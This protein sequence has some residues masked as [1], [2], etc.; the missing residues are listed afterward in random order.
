MHITKWAL[1]KLK[2]IEELERLSADVFCLQE[3]TERSLH[4]TF[5]PSFKKLGLECA[6]FGVAKDE[7]F[8]KSAP[9]SSDTMMSRKLLDPRT[10]G[11]AVFCDSNVV[12]VLSSKRVFLRDFA[13]LGSSR[14]EEFCADVHGKTNIMVML[15]LEIIGTGKKVVLANTHLFWD[16]KREDIKTIQG[17]AVAGALSKFCEVNGF[18]T[19]DPPPIILCGDFNGMPYR[20]GN[21]K[22]NP[23]TD[24]NPA[25]DSVVADTAVPDSALFEL[26]TS[27][28]LPIDHPQHPDRWYTRVIPPLM[29]PRIGPLSTPWRLRNTFML[30]PF[31]PFAPAFTTKTNDFAGWIDHIWVDD[32]QV[33]VT[34]TLVPPV[35]S[36]DPCASKLSQDFPPMPNS[37]TF[38]TPILLAILTHIFTLFGFFTEICIGPHPARHYCNY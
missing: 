30:T 27:G 4:K 8:S 19:S 12:K 24:A 31:V 29:C 38:A 18:S 26:L 23:S 14:S 6:G 3:I 34:H 20:P 16:P 5:V 21:S 35:C 7:K 13:P 9:S 15:L 22:N 10:L 25:P 37:V 2:L 1:R 17:Y 11:C 32:Q 33:E 36:A 28:T